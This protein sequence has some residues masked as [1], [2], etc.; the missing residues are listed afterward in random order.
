[1]VDFKNKEEYEIWK[2]NKIEE[3]NKPKSIKD[4]LPKYLFWL[5]AVMVLIIIVCS[6]EY[7]K[8]VYNEGYER[9]QFLFVYYQQKNDGKSPMDIIASESCKL[10]SQ[11]KSKHR[12]EYYSGCI[13]G[14]NVIANKSKEESN[15]TASSQ[16]ARPGQS[17]TACQ[18]INRTGDIKAERLAEAVNRLLIMKGLSVRTNPR[19]ITNMTTK[20]CKSNPQATEDD[21]TNLVKK[22]TDILEAA[23]N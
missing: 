1:M 4:R 10:A 11:E 15:K 6:K 14:F 16:I 23:G 20:F 3:A 13:E 5:F 8:N 9:G 12:D 18:Y 17:E 7:A 21:L 22:I 19:D 2:A